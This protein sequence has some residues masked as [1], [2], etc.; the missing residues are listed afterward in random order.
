MLVI[1]VMLW[2]MIGSFG[3]CAIAGASVL[4]VY[5]IKVIR[6]MWREGV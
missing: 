4:S 6:K 2:I 5:C 1:D 3:I